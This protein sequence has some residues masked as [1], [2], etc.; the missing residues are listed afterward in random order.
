MSGQDPAVARFAIINAVRLMG[1]ACVL[2]GILIANGQLFAGAPLWIG[3]LLLANGL[4]DV[5]VI[6]LILARKWRTPK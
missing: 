2:V 1:V 4:I 5:F 3:Y 6:P